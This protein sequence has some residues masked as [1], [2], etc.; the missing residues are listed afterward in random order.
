M[1]SRPPPRCPISLTAPV[2]AASPGRPEPGPGAG[3]RLRRGPGPRRHARRTLRAD[4]YRKGHAHPQQQETSDDA[5]RAT[6]F[7]DLL[8][9]LTD[10]RRTALFTLGAARR[11]ANPHDVDAFVDAFRNYAIA[12]YQSRLSA[13]SGQ[14]LKVTGSTERAPGDYVVT[15]VLVDPNGSVRQAA[16]PGRFPR[17]Q[18]QAA[19]SR[20][21]M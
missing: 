7:R 6:E 11:T 5:Q 12:V 1:T 15:T 8:I 13:Y 19:A 17:R 9:G 10:I 18:G 4:Q 3:G 21:W 2:S 14:T 20:C 16:D